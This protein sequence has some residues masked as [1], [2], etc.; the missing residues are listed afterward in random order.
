MNTKGQFEKE[1]DMTITNPSVSTL[2]P[3]VGY[4]HVTIAT[5]TQ[6]VFC[7]GQGALDAQGNMV[8]VHDLTAQTA[9]AVKNLALALEAANATLADIVKTTVYVVGLDD[10][11]LT[12]IFAGL[13]AASEEIG[14]SFP[15]VAG[16][17]VGV[18]RLAVADA[19]IEIE[20]I[21]VLQ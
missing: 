13:S 19:L 15:V 18:Q 4:A 12:H 2:A 11:S 9:Q 8:G 10:N 20:V 21:A 6:L 14:Q 3:A 7:A 1:I 16:T 5:G 17:L